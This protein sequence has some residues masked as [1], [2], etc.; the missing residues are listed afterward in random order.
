MSVRVDTRALSIPHSYLLRRGV[1][2]TISAPIRYGPG[3]AL[4]SPVEAESSITIERPD[5]TFLASG[6]AVVVSSS[7]ATYTLTPDASEALNEG[8]TVYWSLAFDSGEPAEVFRHEAMLVEYHLFP[9]ISERELYIREPELR[10]KVP[11]SQKPIAKG[12]DG[13]GW[14]PQ[15][16]DAYHWVIRTLIERGDRIW[17]CRSATGLRDAVEVLCLERCSKAVRQDTDGMWREKA[18]GYGFD[19]RTAWAKVRLQYDDEN[20]RVRRGVSAFTRMS[21]TGRPW[22]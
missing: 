1:E 17:K 15:I 16:D 8:W 20:P 2:Q 22:I 7:T 3:G 4:V 10:Y 9:V 18:K 11:Q 6:A 5:G 21:P 13:T 12:G 14:Q 19:F